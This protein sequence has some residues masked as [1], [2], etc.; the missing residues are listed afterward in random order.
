MYDRSWLFPL[1]TQSFSV[2][3]PRNT[4]LEIYMLYHGTHFVRHTSYITEYNSNLPFSC[5]TTEYT[6]YITERTFRDIYVISRKTEQ[7]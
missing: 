2:V 1:I 6:C 3:I 7:I 5:Y 4:L